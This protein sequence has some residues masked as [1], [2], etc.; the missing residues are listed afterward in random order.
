MGEAV[1]QHIAKQRGLDITVDSA[2]TAGYHVGEEPDE[3]YAQGSSLQVINPSHLTQLVPP[4]P[5]QLAKST[6][7]PS[8]VSLD[9]CRP[10][11]SSNLPTSSP[12]T[13][14]TSA[15]SNLRSPPT[16]QH[17]CGYGAPTMMESLFRILTMDQ[18]YVISKCIFV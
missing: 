1:L 13:R 3:R 15:T 10:R 18:R 5:L 8:T 2:G 11:I 6:E 4:E 16:P 7:F 12:P 9:K 17:R 14:T